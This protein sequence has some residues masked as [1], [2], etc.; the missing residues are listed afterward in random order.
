MNCLFSAFLGFFLLL[1]YLVSYSVPW[2]LLYL[3]PLDVLIQSPV[4][5]YHKF[6]NDDQIYIAS[7]NSSLNSRFGM[8][9]GSRIHYISGGKKWTFSLMCWTSKKRFYT[10][11]PNSVFSDIQLAAWNWPYWDY[12][13]HE[14]QQMVQILTP[15]RISLA[16]HK[17][18]WYSGKAQ[19]NEGEGNAEELKCPFVCVCV[20]V[21]EGVLVIP[22]RSFSKSIASVY[23]NYLYINKVPNPD[24]QLDLVVLG[25]L[26]YS[27]RWNNKAGAIY[28]DRGNI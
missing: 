20:L 19:E 28:E 2:T 11:L 17:C 4:F 9:R 6:S 26:T 13:I 12:F 5:K 18:L 27:F 1:F 8:K 14:Y 22:W 10:S 16:A 21:G 24:Q 25:Y 15:S 23:L 3:H 7:F